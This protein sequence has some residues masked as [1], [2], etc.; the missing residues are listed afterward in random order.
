M[1]FKLHFHLLAA[2]QFENVL[3]AHAACESIRVAFREKVH[4]RHGTIEHFK[5]YLQTS[6]FLEAASEFQHICWMKRNKDK[7]WVLQEQLLP[8]A[9]LSTEEKDK[10][11]AIVIEAVKEFLA[12]L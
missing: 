2:D 1:D 5:D 4:N 12:G 9:E 3:A 10:D 8:Y 7:T 11:R 6:E